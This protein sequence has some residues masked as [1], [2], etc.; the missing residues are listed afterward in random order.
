MLRVYGRGCKHLTVMPGL[1]HGTIVT[2]K[3][4]TRD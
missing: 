4:I 3:N 1:G 2:D